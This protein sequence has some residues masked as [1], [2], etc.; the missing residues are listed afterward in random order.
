MQPNIGKESLR[1]DNEFPLETLDGKASLYELLRETVKIVLL[2]DLSSVLWMSSQMITMVFVGNNLGVD[3]MSQ[4]SAGLLVFNVM[5]MSIV[6]GLGSAIDTICSQAF[7][8]NP[9]SPVIGETLQRAL[10]INFLFWI[11]MSFIFLNSNGIMVYIFGS[12]V[13]EGSSRFLA[14]CSLYLLSQIITGTINKILFAQRLPEIVACA[15]GVAALTSPIANYYLTPMGIEGAALSLTFTVAFSAFTNILFCLFHPKVVV[16]EARWPSPALY[17]K[18]GWINFMK[19]GIPSLV[20]VCAEWWAFEIQSFFA[21]A[22]SSL[23]LAVFGVA[24]NIVSM[25]FSVALG[26]SV[27]ASVIVG[28]AL[29]GGRP[30]YAQQYAKFILVC[31]IILGALTALTMAYFGS[32]IAQLYTNVPELVSAVESTMPLVIL[33]HV[34]DSLQFCLQGVF[35]GAGKPEQAA[36]A[37]VL[38]LWLVGMPSSALYVFVFDWGVKGVIGGLLTGFLFEIPL[39]YFMMLQWDWHK[40]AIEAKRKSA[41]HQF[42]MVE[43]A[44]IS[45]SDEG[46]F[47]S[48]SVREG[49]MMSVL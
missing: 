44:N 43:E 46:D 40:L 12:T 21:A 24:M 47:D 45:G 10:I 6:S 4:Y 20:A 48:S 41:V 25:M 5:A 34:G 37:V 39:L 15:N 7:G 16:R 36:R 11:I 9:R 33:A 42:V 31:D 26:L 3:G 49:E 38:T 18:E 28:N 30:I 23:A 14:N 27:S 1:E 19:V 35:R 29:G 2:T 17:Q 13:G 32:H 22:I 8:Q